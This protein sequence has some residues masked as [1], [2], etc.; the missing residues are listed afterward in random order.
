MSSSMHSDHEAELTPDEF[1]RIKREIGRAISV[2]DEPI[3]A[4]VA[5]DYP[6]LAPEAIPIA[7]KL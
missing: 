3:S 6:E 4:K 1:R 7:P 5:A 2:T